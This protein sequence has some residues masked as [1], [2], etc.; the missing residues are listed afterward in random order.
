MPKEKA[1]GV[2]S[3]KAKSYTKH[4]FI[5]EAEARLSERQTPKKESIEKQM[6]WFVSVTAMLILIIVNFIG[7]LL[8]VPFLLFFTGAAQYA[9]IA[10][11]AAGFGFLFNMIIHS[12]EHL[13]DK[14]HLIAGIVVPTFAFIDIIILFTLLQKAVEKLKI[15]ASYN[16][17]L[18]VVLFVVAFLVPYLFDIVRGKHKFQ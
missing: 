12:F 13:G 17:T 14:H 2:K 18:I 4:P 1:K 11:F 16:Y 5:Q 7:A 6:H 15:V 3:Y 9:I 8:L 10:V